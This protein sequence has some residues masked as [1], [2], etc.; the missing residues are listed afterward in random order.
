[1]CLRD[2]TLTRDTVR[3][4]WWPNFSVREHDLHSGN[5]MCVGGY[6][7]YKRRSSDTDYQCSSIAVTMF[8]SNYLFHHATYICPKPKSAVYSTGDFIT[9]TCLLASPFS[10]V[11]WL[12][13]TE[14][15][16]FVSPN[17]ARNG[18]LTT[19]TLIK[20]MSSILCCS[21]EYKSW[22]CCRDQSDKSHH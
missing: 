5:I 14:A 4:Y 15:S 18:F 21:Q 13:C 16:H 22:F 17:P 12:A 6:R 20:Q 8:I 1:M 2:M 3:M 11:P 10:C 19:W 9:T 7:T